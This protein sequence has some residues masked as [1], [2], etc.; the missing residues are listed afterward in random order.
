MPFA[1]RTRPA[2][3]DVRLGRSYKLAADVE[4]A[5][6]TKHLD[7]IQSLAQREVSP[8]E[9]HVRGMLLCNSRRDYYYSRFSLGALDEIAEMVPGAPV[10]TGHDYRTLPIGRFFAAKHTRIEESGVPKRDQHWVEALY[11]APKDAEGDTFVNR[12]D[13]GI[14]REVSIGFRLASAPCSICSK[15]I[16]ACEHIPGEVYGK[17]SRASGSG[18][19]EWGMEGITSVLEGSQVFRGGQKDTTNFIP[20]GYGPDAKARYRSALVGEDRDFTA[21]LLLVAKRA[22]IVE[23]VSFEEWF[24][25]EGGKRALGFGALFGKRGERANTQSLVCAKARFAS[26]AGAAKWVRDHDW[27]ADR[28]NETDTDFVF[29]Q[30]DEKDAEPNSFKTISLDEG[31]NAK[32]CRVRTPSESSD[33]T[34]GRKLSFEEFFEGEGAESRLGREVAAS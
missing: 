18:I 15:N 19:C 11:F 28:A 30:F 21:P 17:Q 10:M 13:L 24:A 25:S 29:A 1:I 31:V 4:R 7:A 9:F 3:N 16:W 12:V 26:R 27:R 32:T 34:E 22:N 20:D 14:W 6:K 23:G 33:D 2:C 5:M 8:D